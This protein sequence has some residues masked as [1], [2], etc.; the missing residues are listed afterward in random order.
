MMKVSRNCRSIAL[1]GFGALGQAVARELKA[2]H[3]P[4][5]EFLGALVPPASTH[6]E[7]DRSW[8]SVDDLLA[9]GPDLVVEVAGHAALGSHA[10]RCLEA[11]CDLVAAS[12]GALMDPLLR[13]RL[14]DSARLGKSRLLVP[15]GALGGLDYLRAARR[16]GEVHVEYRGSKPVAAWHG[17]AAEKL[18]D[19]RALDK[20]TVFFRGDAEEAATRFPQ[21]ANVVAA[22]A[23]AVG[24]PQAVSVEL[25]ADPESESNSHEVTAH[26]EAGM[27]RIVVENRP[28]A[29]NP[30]SSRITAFSVLDAVASHWG[31]VCQ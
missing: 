16:V 30:K 25:V 12:V 20:R 17:T 3:L 15:S 19:L 9:A 5:V 10:P 4:G 28:M 27:M 8:H 6:A 23:L 2:G 7:L 14:W 29:S 1:I 31:D 21:N 13:A 18:T 26:G 24:D 22:L 11:G